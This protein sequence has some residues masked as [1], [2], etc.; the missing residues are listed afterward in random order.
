[1]MIFAI[2]CTVCMVVA[3]LSSVAEAGLRSHAS[4]DSLSF[5]PKSSKF[6]NLPGPKA[7]LDSQMD[8]ALLKEKDLGHEAGAL[9]FG[10]VPLEGESWKKASL[11]E[12]LRLTG[13]FYGI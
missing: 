9:N 4:F 5:G 3:C 1:M 8:T 6:W 2:T 10:Q 7:D 13:A 12:R 11:R